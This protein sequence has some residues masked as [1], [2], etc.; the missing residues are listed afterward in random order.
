MTGP[1]LCKQIKN[2]ESLEDIFVILASKV[3]VSSEHQ[4]EGLDIGADAYII[5]PISDR[6]FIAEVHEGELI[7]RAKDALREKE[8][9][10]EESVS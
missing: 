10:Q 5:L 6:E 1:D 4:T 3:R 9:D 8:R 2:D 7:K